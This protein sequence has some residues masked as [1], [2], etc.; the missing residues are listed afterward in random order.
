MTKAKSHVA[1][2]A[3]GRVINRLEPVDKAVSGTVSKPPGRNE[4]E[5]FGSLDNHDSGSR[6]SKDAAKALPSGKIGTCARR[7]RW[8]DS[9]GMAARMRRA[10][11]EALLVP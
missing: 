9:D 1:W 5:R 8:G 4:S 7:F 3:G 10:T 11:G 2:T 6:A